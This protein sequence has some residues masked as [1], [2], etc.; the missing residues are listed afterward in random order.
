MTHY[1]LIFFKEYKALFFTMPY[2]FPILKFKSIYLKTE[3]ENRT[4]SFRV[5]LVAQLVKNPPAMHETP[6][7]LLGQED[8]LKKGQ[9]THSS[10]PGFLWWLRW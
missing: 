1:S 4:S 9:A 7:G 2:L 6:V 5:S 10:I 3:V 8:S